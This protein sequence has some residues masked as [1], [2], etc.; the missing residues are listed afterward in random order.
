MRTSRFW[1]QYSIRGAAKPAE[2]RSVKGSIQK[3]WRAS[4]GLAEEPMA[5]A[6]MVLYVPYHQQ[7]GL[8][9]PWLVTHFPEPLHSMPGQVLHAAVTPSFS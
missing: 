8:P 9:G 7:D 5:D 3:N 1:V 2:R 4:L 6:G